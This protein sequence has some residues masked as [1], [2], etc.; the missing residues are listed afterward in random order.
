[1]LATFLKG[2]EK[3]LE[4]GSNIGRGSLIIASI[5]NDQH[6]FLTLECDPESFEKLNH[7]KLINNFS[8]YT[9]N[10]ALSKRKLIQKGWDTLCSDE[11]I[12]GY[13]WINT[14][15]LEELKSKYPIPFDTLFLDCEGAFYYI[16]LDTPEILNGVKTIIKENDYHNFEH[17]LIVNKILKD[18]GFKI[19][20]Q[21]AGGWGGSQNFFFETWI[22]EN[23]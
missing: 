7:N 6:N 22:R 17:K 1:M 9:E 8:F 3:V 11:L 10:S 16:L 12:E 5:L 2:N 23:L 19:I 13:K 14:I 21:K 4:I 18:N 15:T 20:Y